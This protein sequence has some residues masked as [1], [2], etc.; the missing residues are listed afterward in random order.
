MNHRKR[1]LILEDNDER[2]KKF[3]ENLSLSDLVIVKEASHAI[4]KLQNESWDA[5]FLDHD[6]GGKTYVSTNDEN[7]GS[8]V[9][10]WL[11]QNGDK[12]PELVMIHSLNP[13]GQQNMKSL[14]PSAYVLPFLWLKI[15]DCNFTDENFKLLIRLGRLP[16]KSN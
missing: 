10:R 14:L 7:T 5:L 13:P 3:K 6:L 12:I 9:A 8:A 1:I 15:N 4:H 16:Y 11:N 2:I